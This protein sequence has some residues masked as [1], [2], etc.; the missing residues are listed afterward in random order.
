M[1]ERHKGPTLDD[2]RRYI[3]M[4][5]LGVFLAALVAYVLWLVGGIG[6]IGLEVW[7]DADIGEAFESA[8]VTA[9]TVVGVVAVFRNGEKLGSTAR[10]SVRNEGMRPWRAL[11]MPV[12]AAV[13]IAFV[14]ALLLSGWPD[15]SGPS[16]A[17]P[18]V[19]T[20]LVV[21]GSS[22]SGTSSGWQESAAAINRWRD[23]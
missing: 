5:V 11:L 7:A 15:A 22:L 14:V 17:T 16:K 9:I 23:L 8:F 6:V 3:G 2:W 13:I 12:G 19:S 21:L 10:W 4:A 20:F 1:H 18:A